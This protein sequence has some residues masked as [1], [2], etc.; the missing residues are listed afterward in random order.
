MDRSPL[1]AEAAQ[2]DLALWIDLGK[3]HDVDPEISTAAKKVLEHHLWY[4]SDETVGL[5]LFSD[6][7]PT[8][9]KVKIV[10]GMKTEPGERNV[11]GDATILNEGSNLGDFATTRTARLLPR[12]KIRD[13][14][15]TLPP[16]QWNENE[17]YQHGRERVR[18]LRVINDTAERGVKLFEDFNRLIT[19]DEEEKQFLLQVVEANRKAIPTQTT[20]KCAIDAVSVKKVNALDS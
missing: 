13:S 10:Q 3:Y 15:L 8:V 1:A 9:E 12:L 4:L 2:Q 7:V 19:N 17:D 20:K 5:A 16:D 11:R 18:N 6:R 14:F